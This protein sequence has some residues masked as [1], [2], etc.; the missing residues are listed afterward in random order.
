M[1]LEKRPAPTASRVVTPEPL[2]LSLDECAALL[3]VSRGYVVLQV[4]RGLL[5]KVQIGR[6]V[7]IPREDLERFIAENSSRE[8]KQT[9]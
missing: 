4:H 2:L 3:G 8:A 9:A 6:R 1:A 7:L 5:E